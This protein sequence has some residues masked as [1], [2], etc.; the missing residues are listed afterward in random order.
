M[1]NNPISIPLKSHRTRETTPSQ[2]SSKPFWRSIV[3]KQVGWWWE[4]QRSEWTESIP[5]RGWQGVQTQPWGLKVPPKHRRCHFRFFWFL[6]RNFFGCVKDC[7]LTAVKLT[8]VCTRHCGQCQATGFHMQKCAKI[9]QRC[10]ILRG[11][12]SDTWPASF[13]PNMKRIQKKYFL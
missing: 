7:E 10:H 4:R 3:P 8:C 11:F 6:W 5:A 13:S 12:H 2:Q 1:P 9:W